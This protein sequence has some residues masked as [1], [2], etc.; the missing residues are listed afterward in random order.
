MRKEIV[1]DEQLSIRDIRARL[2]EVNESVK[3]GTAALQDAGDAYEE[4][5]NARVS[6]R[7]SR[8]S[9]KRSERVFSN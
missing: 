5:V 1:V 3:K 4:Y 9:L 2:V 6:K 7:K 8:V